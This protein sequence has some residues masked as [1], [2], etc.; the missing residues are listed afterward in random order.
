MEDSTEFSVQKNSCGLCIA[1]CGYTLQNISSVFIQHWCPSAQGRL[2]SAKDLRLWQMSSGKSQWSG[3]RCYCPWLSALPLHR[4]LWTQDSSTGV[5]LCHSCSS[6]WAGALVLAPKEVKL[7]YSWE[8]EALRHGQAAF[9]WFSKNQCV[10][11]LLLLGF[12]DSQWPLLN[13]AQIPKAWSTGNSFSQKW[14]LKLEAGLLNPRRGKSYLKNIF[15]Q[16]VHIPN[17]KL[18]LLFF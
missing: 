9:G 10:R 8:S 1:H 3:L 4:G 14:I 6:G 7:C 2:C 17:I 13:K 15:H 11:P 18:Y 16:E 12:I 5:C